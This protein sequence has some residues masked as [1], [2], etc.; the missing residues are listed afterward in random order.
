MSLIACCETWKEEVKA[1]EIKSRTD[2][3]L[4]KQHKILWLMGFV[5]CH[6]GYLK[7]KEKKNYP[8]YWK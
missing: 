4:Y 3:L 6:A 1:R 8:D 7:K 5:L 2:I